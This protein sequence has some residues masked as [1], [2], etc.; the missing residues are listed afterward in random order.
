MFTS[1]FRTICTLYF[2]LNTSSF[3]AAANHNAIRWTTWSN[4]A[5]M[6]KTNKRI[7]WKTRAVANRFVKKNTDCKHYFAGFTPKKTL[8]VLACDTHNTLY[9][10]QFMS[11]GR[12]KTKTFH[13]PAIRRR[14][15]R[16]FSIKNSLH[17]DG[18]NAGLSI[19]SIQNIE[20][21]FSWQ[22]DLSRQAHTGDQLT[23]IQTQ[24]QWD[25]LSPTPYRL[26]TVRL[27]HHNKRWYAFWDNTLGLYVNRFGT[28]VTSVHLRYPTQFKRISSPYRPKRLHPILGIRR[29]HWGVDY[30]ANPGNPIWTTAKGRVIW[31]G[32]K[33]G[34][35]KTVIIDH[36]DGYT[37][38]YAHMSR[39]AKYLKKGQYIRQG[40][41]IGYV[42]QT[43]LATGPHVHYEVRY[44]GKPMDPV[45]L[46]KVKSSTKRTYQNK[47]SFNKAFRL[48]LK[49]LG[50]NS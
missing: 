13:I 18:L 9:T 11:N 49:W 12:Y 48:R 36:L 32:R 1:I 43:G 41:V 27:T 20:R 46:A 40:Q 6:I 45:V 44:H 38:T 33:G 19:T 3:A 25:G 42:G 30:A 34:Y 31:V 8:K 16:R 22:V 5:Y 17:R 10:L 50:G 39:Y 4:P 29:P 35:G 7:S 2:L 23:V 26:D 47:R 15:V 28:P 21:L 24:F 37:T 14:V